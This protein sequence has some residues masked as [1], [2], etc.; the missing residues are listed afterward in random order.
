M[1][2]KKKWD[3]K[4]QKEKKGLEIRAKKTIQT[5]NR[6]EQKEFYLAY[7]RGSVGNIK[8]TRKTKK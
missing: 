2:N 6:R 5:E 4:G 7:K 8:L 3:D 1:Q